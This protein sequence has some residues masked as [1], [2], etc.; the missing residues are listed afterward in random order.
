MK[1]AISYRRVSTKEQD[2]RGTSPESQSEDIQ[3]YARNNNLVIVADYFDDAS[4]MNL[5]RPGITNAM[6]A[7]SEGQAGVFV[8]FDSDRVSRNPRDYLNFREQLAEWG[9][10]LHYSQRGKVDFSFG[11]QV[12][13]DIQG[14]FAH[15]WRRKIVTLTSEGKRKKASEGKVITAKRPPYG[16]RAENGTLIIHEEE[17]RIVRLIFKLY[18]QGTHNL[19]EIAVYLTG[20]RI[21]S[22]ADVHAGMSQPKKWHKGYWS[23]TSVKQ[24]IRNETYAGIWHFGKARREVYYVDGVKKF[25]YVPHPKERWIPIEVPAL[26]SRAMWEKAQELLIVNKRDA[27]RNLKH[28]A[29][30]AKRLTCGICGLR[31]YAEAQRNGK[32]H[33]YYY[34][35]SRHKHRFPEHQFCTL[36][37]FQGDTLENDIWQAIKKMLSDPDY[38]SQ[39]I[40]VSLA[41]SSNEA[42]TIESELRQVQ[43]E[44]ERKD[45]AIKRLLLAFANEE[46]DD[47]IQE[48]R[49][50]LKT[51]L[52]TLKQRALELE[53]KLSHLSVKKDKTLEFASVYREFEGILAL[54]NE[55]PFV[56]EKW[57]KALDVRAVVRL[58]NDLRK[59]DVTC[60][61]DN[62]TVDIVDTSAWR[63]VY[64]LPVSFTITLSQV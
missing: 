56:I 7:L 28:N 15:E 53:T 11:G 4:G 29:L 59:A 26:V 63:R 1:K 52:Y 51:E 30:L 19:S 31:L 13:E 34:C 36:P 25:R 20:L 27:S 55:P 5:F 42:G 44:I 2:E 10:E 35:A 22:H 41:Q 45:K 48:T 21:P 61:L 16:Y 47:D 58:E 37:Y 33:S 46:D 14:R 40:D 50:Q 24:I 60:I 12:I 49:Q 54:D 6:A 8:A 57:I 18:T 62:F 64:N 32:A 23:H 3:R 17:A 9:V 39:L 43:T 38:L